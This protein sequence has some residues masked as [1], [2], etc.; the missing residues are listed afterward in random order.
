M[1]IS[2]NFSQQ[3]DYYYG[4]KKPWYRILG[5]ILHKMDFN[6]EFSNEFRVDSNFEDIFL[7]LLN[8]TI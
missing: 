4:I 8:F 5:M 1:K 6:N 7:L 3:F 2:P